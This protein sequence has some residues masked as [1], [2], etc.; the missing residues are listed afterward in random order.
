LKTVGV[1]PERIRL[2]YCTAAEGQK[3]Q[4]EATEY[5]KVIQKLGPSPLRSKGGTQEKAKVKE[6]AKA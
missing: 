6:K 3:F 1:N 4:I 2:V 5:D